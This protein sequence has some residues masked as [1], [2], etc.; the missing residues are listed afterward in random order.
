MDG[1]RVAARRDGPDTEHDFRSYLRKEDRPLV[2][3]EIG[4]WTFFPNFAEM[5]KYTGVMEPRNFEIVRDDMKSKGLLDLAPK[6]R[7][8]DGPACRFTLQGRN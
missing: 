2:G 7:P 4:Q 3:H 1:E 6:I 5:K 8:S